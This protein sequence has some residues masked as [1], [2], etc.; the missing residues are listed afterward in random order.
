LDLADCA[1]LAVD[2]ILDESPRRASKPTLHTKWGVK[3][4]ILI[5]E[6]AK[7]LAAEMLCT[8]SGKGHQAAFRAFEEMYR[9]VQCGQYLDICYE[10]ADMADVTEDAYLEMVRLTTGVQIAG[11]CKIGAILAGAPAAMV[12][13]ARVYGLHT[14]TVFQIRDD[15]I[16]YLDNEKTIGKPPLL[17]L[18]RGKKRLPLL[19]AWKMG[20]QDDRDRLSELAGSGAPQNR[21]RRWLTATITTD[22]VVGRVR[23]IVDDLAMKARE[24]LEKLPP[25]RPRT[26]LA[27]ILAIGSEV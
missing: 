25:G 13:A 18:V 8:G 24:Q 9:G 19:L 23:L 5:A 3:T 12:E 15:L 2:D 7:S 6:V 11:C 22:E 17:D 14:G 1:V 21:D 16:D 27:G 26:L 20:T 10:S 4:A